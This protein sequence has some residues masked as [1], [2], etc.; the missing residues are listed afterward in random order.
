MYQRVWMGCGVES[1]TVQLLVFPTQTFVCSIHWAEREE[2]L[3]KDREI[4]S[5]IPPRVTPTLLFQTT[6]FRPLISPQNCTHHTS[7]RPPDHGSNYAVLLNF[8]MQPKR[9]R[10]SEYGCERETDKGPFLL[11]NEMALLLCFPRSNYMGFP[12]FFDQK[13]LVLLVS[14]L[15]DSMCSFRIHITQ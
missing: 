7:T 9:E 11:Y 6:P 8:S 12:P 4:I 2:T 13:L 15:Q 14:I 1:L 3:G 10:D 5:C